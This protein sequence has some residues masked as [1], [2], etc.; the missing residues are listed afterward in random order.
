MLRRRRSRFLPQH[1]TVRL[2][3]S[4]AADTEVAH[5]FTQGRQVFAPGFS[6]AHLNT[7]REAV[8][9]PVESAWLVCVI[10][11]PSLADLMKAG[12]GAASVY[13]VREHAVASQI[14]AKELTN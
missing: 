13:P 4:V 2:V 14:G 12:D 11:H 7:I 8:A 1:A 5:G 3:D 9:M 6:V 10:Y